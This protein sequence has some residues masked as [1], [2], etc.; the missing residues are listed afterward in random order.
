MKALY[1]E[2]VSRI[3]SLELAGEPRLKLGNF[4]TG[5]KTLPVRYTPA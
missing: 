4:V 1:A 3:T 2:L 5:L